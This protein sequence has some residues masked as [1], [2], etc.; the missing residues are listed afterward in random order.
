MS[1]ISSR[2]PSSY[3]A[4][5]ANETSKASSANGATRV[6][7]SGTIHVVEIPDALAQQADGLQKWLVGMANLNSL[8]EHILGSAQALA[9]D[10]TKRATQALGEDRAYSLIHKLIETTIRV[11]ERDNAPIASEI[12]EL[13]GRMNTAGVTIAFEQPVVSKPLSTFP[14]EPRLHHTVFVDEAG[15]ASWS[16]GAQPV[17]TLC[18]VLADDDR[19]PDFDAA[20]ADLLRSVGVDPTTEIHAQ[21]MLANDG[22]LARLDPRARFEFLKRFLQ[23]GVWNCGGIHHLGMLK[24]LVQDPFRR[25]IARLG[26]DAYTSAVVYFNVALRAACLGKVGVAQYRYLF[27][28]TDKYKRDIKQI[29]GALKVETNAGLKIFAITGEPTPVDSVDHRFVQLA[30]VAGY[31]LTRYRQL[32][33]R[34]FR[35]PESLLKH[36]AEI[37]EVYEVLKPKILSFVKQD[38]WRLIDWKALDDWSHPR[39]PKGP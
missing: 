18:G 34:T 14:K 35:P 32:E 38:L 7:N 11:S 27:D 37:E 22:V 12:V 39:R 15:T 24:P 10:L 2:A 21:P 19:I 29:I 6:R 13:A 36:R 28:R 9:I 23:L 5:C 17:L 16:E 26:F 3:F 1:I 4:R 31:F 8:D 20:C 25:K 30:D 33:V